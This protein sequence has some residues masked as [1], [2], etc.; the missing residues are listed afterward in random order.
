M[1]YLLW[2]K[3]MV[4]VTS[5]NN[6]STDLQFVTDFIVN[7]YHML[8]ETSGFVYSCLRAVINITNCISCLNTL[9]HNILLFWEEQWN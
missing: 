3:F 6:G 8:L 7:F 2:N 4:C 1:L 5:I 9:R